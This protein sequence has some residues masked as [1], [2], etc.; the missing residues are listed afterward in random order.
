MKAS[1]EL[2]VLL[3]CGLLRRLLRQAISVIGALDEARAVDS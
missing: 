3:R 1:A 2:G